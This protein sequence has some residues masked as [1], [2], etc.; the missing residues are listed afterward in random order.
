MQQNIQFSNK[1]SVRELAWGNKRDD[2]YNQVSLILLTDVL[3]N[4]SSHDV[5]LDTLDWLLDNEDCKALLAY[6]ERNPDEREFF[7]K[8]EARGWQCERVLNQEHLVCEIYWI[9]KSP[10]YIH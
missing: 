6:K 2:R 10:T 4:Q 3:Y 9:Q 1:L 8:V 7:I 5:L